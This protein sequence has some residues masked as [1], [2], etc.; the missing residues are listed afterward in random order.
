VRAALV[1]VGAVGTRVRVLF[2]AGHWHNQKKQE[3]K[4][5]A[6]KKIS[7]KNS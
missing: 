2:M 3:A 6:P 4:T 5:E 7:K 1:L